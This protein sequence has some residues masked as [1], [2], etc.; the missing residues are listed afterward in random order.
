M[1]CFPLKLFPL[2][3]EVQGTSSNQSQGHEPVPF[4]V[5]AEVSS[6]LAD[7]PRNNTQKKAPNN[8]RKHSLAKSENFRKVGIGLGFVTCCTPKACAWYILGT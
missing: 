3:K 7:I 2:P 8:E 1:N 6:V 4:F 5:S